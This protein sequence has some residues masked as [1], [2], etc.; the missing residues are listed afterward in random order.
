MPFNSI[1]AWMMKKRM[2]Q[3]DLF[4]KYPLEVQAE[5]FE[6][7]IVLS[8]ETEWGSKYN[9]AKIT[10]YSD[11]QLQVPLQ[12]YQDIQPSVDRL[13]KGEQNILWST[14][15][16]WFAKSSG[17]TSSRSK[18]IP[19]TQES[20]ADCHYKG[21][22]DLLAI[23]YDNYPNRK[24]YNGKHLYFNCRRQWFDWQTFICSSL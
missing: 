6:K 1:F 4:R 17:T 13:M 24:L 23:Y 5:L 19:V 2:H 3:I 10:S 9:Y 8:K 22:K 16:K 18:L 15:T 20:L 7:M 21:G 11:F 12:E 14:D